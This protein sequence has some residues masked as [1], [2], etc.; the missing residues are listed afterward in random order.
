MKKN[1][2]DK[3]IKL[4]K[5]KHITQEKLAEL[6]D[7]SRSKVSSWETNRR[8]MSITEAIK[9]AQ[10]YEVSLDY[11]FEIEEINKEQYIGISEKFIKNDKIKLKEKVKIIECIKKCLEEN[12]IDEFYE[13]Y[14]M[15]Q[16]ATK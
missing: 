2:I 7:I 5:N 12:N 9:L 13:N 3:M 14:K 6:L 10:I 16:N 4:R 15:T 8:E 11:L 1:I